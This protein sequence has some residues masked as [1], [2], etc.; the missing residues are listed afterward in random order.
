MKLLWLLLAQPGG[1]T[2]EGGGL[3]R[4]QGVRLLRQVG[5]GGGRSEIA[6]HS[7]TVTVACLYYMPL[8]PKLAPSVG[9]GFTADKS[10]CFGG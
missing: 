1:R 9:R 8:H 5:T 4:R 6:H 2:S 3:L 7:E 10:E